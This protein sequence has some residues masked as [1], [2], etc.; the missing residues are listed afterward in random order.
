MN[1]RITGAI[2]AAALAVGLAGG[3]GACGSS[4]SSPPNATQILQADGYTPSAAYTSDFQTGLAGGDGKVTSSEAGTQG[5]NVQVVIVLDNSSDAGSVASGL[6]TQFSGLNITS[7]G[8]VVTVTG[9]T[10]DF[11]NIG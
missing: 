5:D 3:I 11:A 9:S 7:N 2:A 4:G 10:S 6:Q 1:R 8:D